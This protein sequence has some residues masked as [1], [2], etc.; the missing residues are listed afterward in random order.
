[1]PQRSRVSVRARPVFRTGIDCL[2]MVDEKTGFQGKVN[3]AGVN[4]HDV[5]I[6]Q[7]EFVQYGHEFA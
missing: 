4:G 5:V 3:L 1:M 6:G 7:C 2:E